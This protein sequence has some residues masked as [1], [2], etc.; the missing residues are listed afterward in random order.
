MQDLVG[1]F[2]PE[3]AVVIGLEEAVIFN[4]L[5]WCVENPQ[6][7]GTIDNGLKMIRNPI[8]CTNP[9]KINNSHGKQ[10][11][12]LGNFIW[13]TAGK[14]RRIFARLEAIGLVV[15]RKLRSYSFDQCKYY[16][17]DYNKLAELL[18]GAPLSICS[19][20]TNR[21]DGNDHIDLMTADKS[22]QDTFSDTPPQYI[23]RE[24]ACVNN[25]E[26]L[27]EENTQQAEVFDLEVNRE[28]KEF[29]TETFHNPLTKA[30]SD[31]SA[32]T[33]NLKECSGAAEFAL[34]VEVASKVEPGCANEEVA[35]YHQAELLEFG[36]QLAELGKQ[37]GKRNPVAWAYTIVKN[38]GNTPC[39]YWE[40]F[41]AGRVLGVSEQQEWE[42]A[43][44]VPCQV[45]VQ[46]LEQDY[47]G[48]QGATPTE[49]SMKAARTI[50]NPS[51]MK[52]IWE[53]MKNRVL[54]Q[55][56]KFDEQKAMG[57]E[58]PAT[59][60]PWMT[61][62][63]RAKMQDVSIALAEMQA[64]LPAVLQPARYEAEQVLLP[65]PPVEEEDS[66]SDFDWPTVGSVAEA[67][68]RTIPAQI[69]AQITKTLNK[70]SNRQT[71]KKAILEANLIELS[72]E[73]GVAVTELPINR[74]QP[75]PVSSS[76]GGTATYLANLEIAVGDVW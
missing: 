75:E 20:P 52:Q 62:R 18:K 63:P 22:Y 53:T 33:K 1:Y 30:E 7:G 73:L 10:I 69:K 2:S 32:E 13:A 58:N 5:Q 49:A 8:A 25:E 38:L 54:Y 65:E 16:S 35:G 14:L 3:L 4:K 51:V 17:I 27:P 42:V 57:I 48:K 68:D 60:D 26:F 45:A 23:E 37:L 34:E 31:A 74:K 19:K 41:K 43:P 59:L 15:A 24:S 36:S 70:F 9:R 29:Q 47:L 12:W 66:D 11:D 46:C 64:A 6:M 71:K 72:A 28:K 61:P 67:S 56:R 40:D 21:S 50:A 39:V 76:E 55:K 44:G